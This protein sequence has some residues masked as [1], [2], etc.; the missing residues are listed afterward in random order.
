MLALLLITALTVCAPQ[1]CIASYLDDF[2]T[3][4]SSN[5]TY[6]NSYGG[7]GS[8]E[9]L[10]GTLNIT[11]GSDNTA[12]VM[13]TGTVRFATG[14]TLSVEV[15]GISGSQGVFMMC[16]TTDAQP[17]GSTT[18]G[19]RF[20]RGGGIVRIDRY[21]GEA[22]ADSTDPNSAEAATMIVT[23]TSDTDFDYSIEINGTETPLG[24]FTLSELSGM[25]DL[26]I[27]AQAY[28]TTGS[29][30]SF[31]NLKVHHDYSCEGYFWDNFENPGLIGYTYEDSYGSGGSFTVSGDTLNITTGSDN[32]ASVVTT[33][34]TAFCVGSTLSVEVPG[35]S[36]SQGVFMMCS[37]T[38]GQPNGTTTYGFRFRRGGGIVRID[39]YPGTGSAD[40]TD[41]SPG[42]SAVLSV[43]RTS[44]TDFDYSIEINGTETPLGSFTIEQLEEFY[45]L[46]IGAQAYDTT[47]STFSFDNLLVTQVYNC[48][49]YFWDN[50][51]NPGVIDYTYEDSY[52]SGGSFTVSGDTLNITTGSNNTASVMITDETA[53]CIGDAL[54]IEVP[55]ISGYQ[56]VFMMCSTTAGQPDGTT[57]YGFRFRRGGGIVRIDRYPGGAVT[58]STDPSPGSPAVL[59]VIRTSG[60]DFDY[61]IEINGTETPLGSFTIEEMSPYYNLHIGAQA[62]DTTGNTF[63]FDNL[64]VSKCGDWGYHS[65]DFNLDCYVNL[66]DFAEFS[67]SWLRCTVPS[68]PGSENLFE[69][70]SLVIIPDTQ[71]WS[72]NDPNLFNDATSWIVANKDS[73]NIQFALHVGDIVNDDEEAYQW[74]NADAAMSILDGEVPYCFGVGNHDMKKGED[75]VWTPDP[76]RD[77]TNFNDKFPY[78]R[79]NSEP[80][81]GGRMTNDTPYIPTENYDNTFHFFSACGMDFLIIC[82][83]V[84]PTDNH[85]TWANSIV[86]SHSDKRVIVVTHS[87]MDGNTRLSSDIYSPPGGN[88][89][90]QIW[91]E[92]IKLHE[93][94][95]FVACGHLA[96]GRRT[97]TGDNGNLLHQTVNNNDLLRILRFV[98]TANMIYVKSYNPNTM[99][100]DTDTENEYEFLYNMSP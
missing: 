8:F 96:N 6:S 5:Y 46:H 93:N 87:Y 42:S 47:G 60:A 66:Q 29:T 50:F 49:G 52:N 53:F 18:F 89:G 88:A 72:K 71:M 40:S 35:V 23:R 68:E 84:A 43:T 90:Q 51:E 9:I 7:G 56:G 54:S 14:E 38:A 99:T 74:D 26:Y 83:S 98:P 76:D 30:F 34:E 32:T 13:T 44:A 17:D 2:S 55:G 41:P 65:M 80:W 48:E 69:E 77:S 70:F 31:D 75:P 64:F 27:G 95:F 25:A 86:S 82:L 1:I 10:D 45:N 58:D 61:F 21:P 97:D 78:T 39:R 100:Y 57:T 20:R 24:S 28:D 92:F 37:T 16:S 33:D 85:L 94:I 73:Q 15:P 12:S 3:D 79:Y 19:F 81:Y 36:G 59:R 22:V 67:K 62:F 4:T 11:T 63:S 91:D